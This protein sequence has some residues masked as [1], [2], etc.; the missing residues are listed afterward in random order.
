MSSS[1]LSFC[2][3]GGA[4]PLFGWLI[5][6]PVASKGKEINYDSLSINDPRSMKQYWTLR[7]SSRKFLKIWFF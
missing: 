3:E 2:G 7:S 5:L 4:L 1:C 6:F